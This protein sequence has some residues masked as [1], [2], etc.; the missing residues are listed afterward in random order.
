MDDDLMGGI[1]YILEPVLHLA[2]AGEQR[3]RHVQGVDP[4]LM[5]SLP[6]PEA[7][8]RTALRAGRDEVG[9]GLRQFQVLRLAPVL[10]QIEHG[11]PRAPV[12]AVSAARGVGNGRPDYI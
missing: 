10:I 11:A 1:L 8:L 4:Q 6:M 5:A 9:H 3:A 2:Q 12:A 7:A